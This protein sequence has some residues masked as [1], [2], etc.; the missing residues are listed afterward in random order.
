MTE[1]A[2]QTFAWQDGSLCEGLYVKE[3]IPG[4]GVLG[5]RKK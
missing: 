4:V 3:E 1:S 5:V 2:E